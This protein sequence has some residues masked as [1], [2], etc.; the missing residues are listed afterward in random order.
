MDV[1]NEVHEDVNTEDNAERG[2]E[3]ENNSSEEDLLL[4]NFPL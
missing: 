4:S 1:V 3:F 2:N